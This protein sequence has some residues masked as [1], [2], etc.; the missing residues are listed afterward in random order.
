MADLESIK[1]ILEKIEAPLLFAAENAYGR[2]SLVKNLEAVMMSLLVRLREEFHNINQQP[3]NNEAAKVIGVLVKLF[4]NYDR[5]SPERRKDSIAEAIGHISI[6]KAMVEDPSEI[7]EEN[8]IGNALRSLPITSVR[9]VGNRMSELLTRMNLSTVEDLLYFL[10]RRYE[11]RRIVTRITETVPGMKQTITGKITYADRCFY[12]RKKVFEVTVDD[13]H[14]ILKAKWFK[15]RE[16][17][18]RGTLK[19]QQ[20]VILT[21]KITGF[22]FE[23][24]MIHP[25][26]EILNDSEDNLL[27]FKR[28]VPVYSETEGLHQKTLRRIMW[29]AVREYGTRLETQIPEAIRRKH[30]LMT[31]PEAV[32]MVHFPDV[33]Q[34]I[35]AYQE[36]RSDAHRTLIYDEFFFFQLGIALSR[37]SV[38]WEKGILFRPAGEILK[39]FYRTLPFTL[40][41]A[42]QRVI[43]EI[44]RDMASRRSM[45]RLL[46][47]DVGSGKTIVSMAA[48][49]IACE[50]GYQAAMMAPTEILA[51]QHY[52]NLKAWS[53]KIGLRV[54]LLTGSLALAEKREI[55][56][57]LMSGGIDIIVGTH[58]LIQEDV[59]FHKLGLVVVDEQHR[60]GVLQRS[61]LRKKGEIPDVLVMTATPI[62]RTLAM[63]VYGDLDISVI[64]ELPPGR[65]EIKTK[66]FTETQRNRVYEIIRKEVHKGNQVFI[67]YP[68]IDESERLDL[69]AATRMRE[70]LKNNI[71]PESSVGL[72]HGRMKGAEK[73]MVMRA[74]VRRQIQILV[75]TTVIEVGID[76]PKASLMV[77]EHSERF[78]LSQLHQ[79]RGRVGRS[80]TPSA[81]ILMVQHNRSNDALKRLKVMEATNDGFKIAEE[82]LVIRGPGEFMGTKQTGLP[83]FYVANIVRDGLIL[84]NAKMDAFALVENDPRLEKPEH[85]FLR[86]KLL[87]RWAGRLDLAR[88]I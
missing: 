65:T 20:R 35:D 32:R 58:A 87:R 86:E 68:L 8:K 10:P 85:R 13:G 71:F 27:H 3:Q 36:G 37:R 73:E 69:R 33:D 1:E 4:D 80:D 49:I 17:F 79:L 63:S 78:G 22:P 59:R 57:Q 48:M 40:T 7:S 76:I 38:L 18:L 23:R 81:C 46:Q 77:I 19:P 64:D 51:D 16:A 24:E 42:Q 60:F 47:G 14:G 34:E 52:R 66:V 50:N 30:R 28:I 26:F 5:S 2:L 25:D 83:D 39:R 55:Q 21:G 41:E 61:R 67:V 43:S 82:D 9:G 45:N 56:A 84:N 53:E 12:G 70:H 72:I 11:D 54:R 88:T 44:Q 15:G 62:P 6:L 74:F 31:I 29:H 75:S